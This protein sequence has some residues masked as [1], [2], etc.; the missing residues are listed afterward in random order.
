[1]LLK[2]WR[3][4]R[5]DQFADKSLFAMIDQ[6][7][8][9]L[10][11]AQR[12]NFERW[13][14]LGKYVWPNPRPYPKTYAGEVDKLKNWLAKRLDWMDANIEQLAEGVRIPSR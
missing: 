8:S 10:E 5:G 2:H 12:R 6:T 4:L 3:T 7:A 14:V 13:P 1:R 9:Q 11:S